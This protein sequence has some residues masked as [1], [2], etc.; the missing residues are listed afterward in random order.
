MRLAVDWPW[1]SIGC[2]REMS[3]MDVPMVPAGRILC[4]SRSKQVSEKW[5]RPTM[6][7][8]AEATAPVLPVTTP[9]LALQLS[10][11]QG[12]SPGISAQ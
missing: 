2:S 11:Q 5:L 10:G 6:T 8:V 12:G 4:L 1:C 9:G 3:G 7:V